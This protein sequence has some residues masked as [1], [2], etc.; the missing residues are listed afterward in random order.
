MT[1]SKPNP[2]EWQLILSKLYFIQPTTQTSFP[3]NESVQL[4]TQV[5]LSGIDSI[6]VKTKAVFENI[7]SN[8]LMN[9]VEALRFEST[10]DSTLSRTYVCL[11]LPCLSH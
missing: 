4:T 7:Y 6:Q 10:L 5:L 8:Q 9:Q 11:A 3:V 1:F 2:F